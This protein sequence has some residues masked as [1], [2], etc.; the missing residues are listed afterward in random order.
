[1]EPDMF[2]GWGV[3]TL[4]AGIPAYN[5]LGYHIGSIWPH[6]NAIILAGFRRYGRVEEL[7]RLGTAMLEAAMAFPDRRVPELFS[8]DARD[9]R[10]VPTPYPVASRPQAW[11]AA[12]L[13]YALMSMLGIGIAP[14][15]SLAI[16][17]PVLPDWLNLVAVRG[18]RF[19]DSSVDLLF[20]CDSGHVSVEVDHRSG[21]GTVVLAREWPV[22]PLTARLQG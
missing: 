22:P 5:P 4:A 3:R 17:R 15:G 13:P 19:G 10:P 20:R 8:G 6:D 21:G 11:S 16:T 18:L 14:D 9:N 7:E 1:M 12:S 2:S